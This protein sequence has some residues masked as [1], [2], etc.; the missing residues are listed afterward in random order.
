MARASRKTTT[1]TKADEQR[2]ALVEDSEPAEALESVVHED[3]AALA[4]DLEVEAGPAGEDGPSIEPF[5][6]PDEV[7]SIPKDVPTEQ[8]TAADPVP[9]A[10]QEVIDGRVP[11]DV[12]LPFPR[13]PFDLEA[14]MKQIEAKERSATAAWSAYES[15][16]E[17]A[18]GLKKD[19]EMED[20]QLHYLIRDLR[21]RREDSQHS[22][23]LLDAVGQVEGKGESVEAQKPG[24]AYERETGKPCPIC[25]DAK[26]GDET[27]DRPENPLYPEHAEA[28]HIRASSETMRADL[29]A[30]N[31]FLAI[32]E[33]DAL[34]YEDAHE[35]SAWASALHL[36]R[37]SDSSVTVPV[38]P[39]LLD[40][41]C[42]A[43]EPGTERQCCRIC[44]TTLLRESGEAYPAGALVGIECL[45][46]ME[47][48]EAARP[49]AK[50]GTKK[51]RK[52][53]DHD[54]IAE[55]QRATEAIDEATA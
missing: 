10:S 53:I 46:E 34:D 11:R 2:L 15:A 48:V 39:A 50:R 13:P 51:S 52:K 54:A 43:A 40:E 35:L 47:D 28:A 7:P 21:T 36:S 22:A 33:L 6:T 3:P 45:G 44:G 25:R 17:R 32:D 38:R 19:A 9:T 41:A 55:E 37:T 4:A 5:P 8:A 16:N 42:E 14:A 24:C 20:E 26:P 49:V 1:K 18:K 30:V 23:G 12:P 31:V 27:I 29:A